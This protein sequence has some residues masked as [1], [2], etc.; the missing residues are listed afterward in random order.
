MRLAF[1]E[2]RRSEI[3]IEK[4]PIIDSPDEKKKVWKNQRYFLFPERMSN[5][6]R[7]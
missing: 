6:M 2:K 3:V 5:V 1:K 4:A 7:S